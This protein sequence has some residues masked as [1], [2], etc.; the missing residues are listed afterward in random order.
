MSGE[1]ALVVPSKYHLHVYALSHERERKNNNKLIITDNPIR[2]R[3]R[4]QLSNT[5]SIKSLGLT[6]QQHVFTEVTETDVIVIAKPSRLTSQQHV[7]REVTETDVAPHDAGDGE[8]LDPLE[9]GRVAGG[10][11]EG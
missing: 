11:V 2:T 8:F 3:C 7:F 4:R 1:S 5:S 9:D 10:V 6:P